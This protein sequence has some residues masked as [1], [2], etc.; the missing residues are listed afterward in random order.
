VTLS[1]TPR[2]CGLS[3]RRDAVMPSEALRKS[4]LCCEETRESTRRQLFDAAAASVDA[5]SSSVRLSFRNI[6]CHF[7][8]DVTVLSP[9]VTAC[10][11]ATRAC[12]STRCSKSITKYRGLSILQFVNRPYIIA[13]HFCDTV[14]FFFRPPPPHTRLAVQPGINAWPAVAVKRQA[15][16]VSLWSLCCRLPEHAESRGNCPECRGIFSICIFILVHY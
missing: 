13:E 5:V 16:A 1:E 15:S 11:D 4:S 6:C 7:V 2:L 9:T 10:L 12:H 14:H 8:A 3:C